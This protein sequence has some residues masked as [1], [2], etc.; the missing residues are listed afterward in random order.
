MLI[1]DTAPIAEESS[2]AAG[3]GVLEKAM[4]LLNI[5]SKTRAPMTFTELLGA[6]NLPKATLHRILATLMREGLLRHDV[7][8]KTYQLGVRL[9]ELAH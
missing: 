5:L 9:L 3:A 1:K 4:S 2:T 8:S 7:Y 6:G